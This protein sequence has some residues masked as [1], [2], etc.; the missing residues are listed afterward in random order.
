MRLNK[1]VSLLRKKN[2]PVSNKLDL[3]LV[4]KIKGNRIPKFSQL[5]YLGQFVS[6]KEKFALQIATLLIMLA[7]VAW[8]ILI[9]NQNKVEVAATGGEYR[10]ALVGQPKFINPL[11]SSTNDVDA[12]ITQLVYSGLLRYGQNQKLLPDLASKYKISEDK[13]IYEFE[14]RQDAKWS[15]GQEF[16]A[17][18]VIFTFRSIQNPLI[19]SPLISTYRGVTVEKISKYGVRF[20]LEKPFSPFLGSLTVGMLPAHIW[21]D[22]QPVNM[23]LAKS[24]TQPVGTGIWK[25]DKLTKNNTGNIQSYS[26]VPNKYFYRKRP[27][28]QK[29][30]LQFY[31]DISQAINV[32][33]SQEVDALSF[34]P[35]EQRDKISNRNF[36]FHNF[37]LPQYTAL[38]FNQNKNKELKDDDLRLALTQA[39]DK[40]QIK[41]EVLSD[42]IQIENAPILKDSI[43]YDKNLVYPI[44]SLTSSSKLLSDDDWEKIQPEKY[45]ELQYKKLLKT[46]EDE[47]EAIKEATSTQD[48]ASSTIKKIEDQIA[49]QVR[50]KMDTKQ[51]FYLQDSDGK[52]LELTITTIDNSEFS[53]VAKAVAQMWQKIGI[54][55]ETQLVSRYQINDILKNRDYQILLYGE[56][57][58]NDPDPY[59]FWHS[60]QTNY[61]GLNLS[62]FSNREADKLLESARSSDTDDERITSYKKF[63]KIFS[64]KLPAIILYTP[65]HT[66]LVNKDIKGIEL[67]NIYSPTD[68]YNN[69]NNWYTKTKKKWFGKK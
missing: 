35:S 8:I 13:K 51:N 29:I 64:D 18:D 4:K 33:K 6:K 66:M 58:G 52:I 39:I 38:F 65:T 21:Q 37:T 43:Y 59:P 54:K 1:I 25:F 69:I 40:E 50:S 49:E 48:T 3:A 14:L 41:K 68:R 55:V 45:F 44:F 47:I 24:N 31:P 32:L 67:T 61:P 36:N 9:F 20:T 56:I 26:L 11:Y 22:I 62:Q 42:N 5:K 30:T 15:D 17:D 7:S 23:K 46:R 16:S 63:Q 60:S 34:V 2:K 19:N 27:Y 53:I 57:I 28:L 10:E 12:D